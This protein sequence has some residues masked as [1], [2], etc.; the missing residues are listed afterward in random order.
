[1]AGLSS[2]RGGG[3]LNFHASRRP[4][5]VRV[6]AARRRR[7]ERGEGPHAAAEEGVP[8]RGLDMPIER[9]EKSI[10]RKEVLEHALPQEQAGRLRSLSDAA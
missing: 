1:M 7:G 6:R 2:G 4:N 9:E 8:S 10:V 3:T 5:P